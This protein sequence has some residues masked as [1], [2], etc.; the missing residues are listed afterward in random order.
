M[1]G[2]YKLFKDNAKVDG[3]KWIVKVMCT[4]DE[5]QMNGSHTYLFQGG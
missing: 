1:N 2:F 5:N 3:L 4:N